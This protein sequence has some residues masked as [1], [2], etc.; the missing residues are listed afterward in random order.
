MTLSAA[1]MHQHEGL[2]VVNAHMF[3]APAFP[4]SVFNQ[5]TGWYFHLAVWLVVVRHVGIILLQCLELRL[6]DDGI[7]EEAAC[8]ADLFHVGQFG[9][10]DGANGIMK[11]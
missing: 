11:L 6:L 1:I 9:I 4:A 10:A 8:A 3:V 5:P 7:L 2:F